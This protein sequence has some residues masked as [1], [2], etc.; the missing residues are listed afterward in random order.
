[1][2]LKCYQSRL[3]DMKHFLGRK[4]SLTML[5]GTTTA[6]VLICSTNSQSEWWNLQNGPWYSS[7]HGNNLSQQHWYSYTAHRERDEPV[8]DGNISVRG[9]TNDTEERQRKATLYSSDCSFDQ[10]VLVQ[11]MLEIFSVNT[12]LAQKIRPSSQ[13]RLDESWEI[14]NKRWGT[15]ISMQYITSALRW[16]ETREYYTVS[17]CKHTFSHSTF[18]LT[19]AHI[20]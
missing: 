2:T 15:C 18:T 16:T 14:G 12:E 1:M 7:F 5:A 17:A 13:R 4:A 8:K 19:P 9:A 20:Y 10:T 11:D 6:K 3:A